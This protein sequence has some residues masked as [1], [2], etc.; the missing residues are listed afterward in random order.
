[1]P[2]Y[3]DITPQECICQSKTHQIWKPHYVFLK[4]TYSFEYFK[5]FVMLLISVW[6]VDFHSCKNHCRTALTKSIEITSWLVSAYDFYS[7]FVEN[8]K[9]TSESSSEWVCDSSQQVNKNRTSEPTMK[10][11]V[12]F[13]STEIFFKR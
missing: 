3:D 12:Y 4:K 1:M 10:L 13:I 2:I 9:R 8:R 5:F 11:F 7:R 6:T